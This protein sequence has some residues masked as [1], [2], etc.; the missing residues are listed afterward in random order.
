MV[1]FAWLTK[2]VFPIERGTSSWPMCFCFFCQRE[3]G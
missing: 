3:T 2:A 1:R